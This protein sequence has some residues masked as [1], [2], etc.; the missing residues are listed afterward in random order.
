MILIRA[1]PRERILTTATTLFYQKGI[2]NVGVDEIVAKSN[3]A[4][5]TLY[6]HFASKDE[7]ITEVMR[8]RSEQWQQWLSQALEQHHGSPK[9]RL[10]AIFSVLG[11]WLVIH[12]FHGC[13]FS[14]AAAQLG[15][16][17]HPAYEFCV[18]PRQILFAHIT[19]LV[20]EADLCNPESFVQ[21]MM[22]LIGGA[23]FTV[24]MEGTS[25]L[26][27]VEYARQAA[28]ALL[29]AHEQPELN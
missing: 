12:E 21:Q 3:V 15:D 22:L 24:N 9:E 20:Q 29:S 4:K 17:Q 28:I 11:Q 2:R 5:T 23:I 18:E 10:I 13:P 16:I 27:T 1:E 19:H 25:A 14:T 7:L 6:H 26:T 8:R